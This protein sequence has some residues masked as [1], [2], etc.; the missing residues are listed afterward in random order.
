MSV[1]EDVELFNIMTSVIGDDDFKAKIRTKSGR[2]SIR[3]AGRP[4]KLNAKK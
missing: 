4:R 1:P 3:G 2:P